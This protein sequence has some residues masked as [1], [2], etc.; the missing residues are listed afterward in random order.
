M[1]RKIISLVAVGK[2]YA[3][4]A[5][6]AIKRLNSTSWEINI[7][8]DDDRIFEYDARCNVEFYHNKIFSYFDKMLF[9]LRC[10]RENKSGV[11][12]VDVDRLDEYP[13][14][15]LELLS[16]REKVTILNYWPE[17]KNFK[18][19]YSSGKHFIPFVKYCD[20]RNLDY[21]IDTFSEEI[22]FVPY[23]PNIESVIYDVEK[24]RPLFEYQSLISIETNK[25]YPNVGNAEGLAFSYALKK[26]GH[27]IERYE[28]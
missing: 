20:E 8:T 4:S 16:E 7:L 28:R 27:T 25:Y 14:N 11:V 21:D 2:N 9:V 24:V 1:S 19:L 13:L 3:D 15:F 26:N 22:F 10:V 5:I 6:D 12:Y 17:S 18:G 23:L